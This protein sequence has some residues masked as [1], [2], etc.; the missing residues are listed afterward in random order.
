MKLYFLR[1]GPAMEA[2]EWRGEDGSRPLTA[3]GKSLMERAAATL[4]GLELGAGLILASPLLRAQ[5]TAAIVGRRLSLVDKIVKEPRLGP[6]FDLPSLATILAQNSSLD[7]LMLVG[8]EPS[9]SRVIASL[10]GGVRIDC[11]KG[12]IACVKLKDP[13]ILAGELSWLLPPRFL[14][15]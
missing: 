9:F 12:S 4:A 13:A 11:K 14:A 15:R 10:T 2:E 1:H 7:A 3:E 6:D 5:E 8:H